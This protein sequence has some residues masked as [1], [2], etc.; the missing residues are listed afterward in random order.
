MEYDKSGSVN[1]KSIKMQDSV[2]LN[3]FYYPTS[4]EKVVK[5][6]FI[7]RGKYFIKENSMNKFQTNRIK[8]YFIR[9]IALRD[10]DS[11]KYISLS[12]RKS[13]RCVSSLIIHTVNT[14]YY[15]NSVRCMR[16]VTKCELCVSHTRDNTEDDLLALLVFLRN[17][18]S[19]SLKVL[20]YNIKAFE[21]SSR[22]F[23]SLAFSITY[24]RFLQIL[25]YKGYYSKFQNLSISLWDYATRMI[26]RIRLL[27]KLHFE[28]VF[29]SSFIRD[30]DN[31]TP[32]ISKNPSVKCLS[33]KIQ[34]DTPE[35][36][37]TVGTWLTIL[38]HIPTIQS[39]KLDIH[40]LVLINMEKFI[41]VL[42]KALEDFQNL[43]EFRIN[44]KFLENSRID[45][46]LYDSLVKK[47]KLKILELRFSKAELQES[48]MKILAKILPKFILLTTLILDLNQSH[49]VVKADFFSDLRKSLISM[50]YIE[51]L[52][53]LLPPE[54]ETGIRELCKPHDKFPK[55][56][57]LC[58]DL[59][60]DAND[61]DEYNALAEF[62]RYQT[63][64]TSLNLSLN[65][66]D[67]SLNIMEVFSR[68]RSANNVSNNLTYECVSRILE[69]LTA[70]S[71]LR[72]ASIAMG[73]L[74]VDPQESN[75]KDPAISLI[76]E[77]NP[78]LTRIEYN[79][80]KFFWTDSEMKKMIRLI[81]LSKKLTEI[82][83]RGNFSKISEETFKMLCE[84]ISHNESLSEVDIFP[85]SYPRDKKEEMSKV[86][87]KF[88]EKQESKP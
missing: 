19:K 27:K 37:E 4:T 9:T 78:N 32:M 40:Q 8:L 65:S 54:K 14:K 87:K 76:L 66:R 74:Q 50:K 29:S 52:H 20:V 36:L 49:G 34:I 62:L 17:D 88:R 11:I 67:N 44:L 31:P 81:Q 83:I 79:L 71:K 56:K 47:E 63:E 70:T 80:G 10:S 21:Q 69:S 1:L 38:A 57:D 5:G 6:P 24:K 12:L 23:K 35:F 30:K 15:R 25:I 26:S 55:L 39:I 82:N 16:I 60:I 59:M 86:L 64:L 68:M 33:Y 61:P 7:F 28:P 75:P 43:S 13:L 42:S 73:D 3:G 58:L 51:R 2:T 77:K 53:I 48:D 72:T 18:V 41:K 84:F 85:M 22:S 45:T 46:S